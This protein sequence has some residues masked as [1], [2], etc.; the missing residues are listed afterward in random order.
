MP[1]RVRRLILIVAIIVFASAFWLTPPTTG[2]GPPNG[3]ALSA[4]E[5]LHAAES[6]GANITSLVN[7][8]NNLLQ[9][10]APNSSFATLGQVA[11][12]A[13]R[14]AIPLRSFDRTLPLVLV[15]VIALILAFVSEVLLQLRRKI[16]RE[17][18]LEMEIEQK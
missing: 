2:Q 18:I 14:D 13:Q 3:T 6:A 10:S 7:Q 9:Q 12:N 11:E 8:Y 4:F 17:K 5:A 1:H 15:P 16:E